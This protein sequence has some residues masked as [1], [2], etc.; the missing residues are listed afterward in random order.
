MATEISQKTSLATSDLLTKFLEDC[1]ARSL[2]PN[3]IK[4]Y[5]TYLRHFAAENPII[6]ID[7]IIIEKWLSARGESFEK[8]GM[9]LGR[10]QSFYD[11]LW[12][13]DVIASS[14][15]P[16]GKMGRPR[17]PPK[18]KRP[19]GRP[20]KNVDKVVE[21]GYER[22]QSPSPVL[23]PSAPPIAQQYS[24]NPENCKTWDI[25]GQFIGFME[26]KG[27]APGTIRNY[28]DTLLKYSEMFPLLP[29]NLEAISSFLSLYSGEEH[30]EYRLAKFRNL[31]AFYYWIADYK[32]YLP[33]H[34]KFRLL[35][36]HVSH[37][38]KANLSNEQ[39]AK[40]L[41]LMQSM[42][43]R[44]RTLIDLIIEAGPRAGEVC[45]IRKEHIQ[46][47][48]IKLKGKTGQ[49]TIEISAEL[50]DR[51]LSLTPEATGPIFFNQKGTPLQKGGLYWLVRGYL[52]QIGIT[53]GKLGPHM[54]RHTFGR[55]YLKNGGTLE[56]LRQMLG[57]TKITTTAIYAELDREDVHTEFEKANPRAN[58]M[59]QL[60]PEYIRQYGA[61]GDTAKAK[62]ERESAKP[63][64]GQIHMD[65]FLEGKA[66]EKC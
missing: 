47:L 24:W 40:F 10:L 23:S 56:G 45:S 29:L 20:R 62:G 36:P 14:P 17:N 37:K 57:H 5:H 52:A 26:N 51:L 49:R 21:G 9:V 19:R 41:A 4:T 7:P 6:P 13:S 12:R 66:D 18:P 54:L 39:A 31:R 48:Y 43:P 16:P 64:P 59:R 55:L 8:R 60:S 32:D 35:T 63:L 53:T 50:R 34:M 58:L 33:A 38:V 44:D 46:D 42:P 1:R 11:Y 2:S 22:S 61:P 25:A 3:T 65:E 15:I 27:Y 30:D 28:R